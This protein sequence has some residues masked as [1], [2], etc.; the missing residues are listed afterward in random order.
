ML[1]EKSNQ[2]HEVQ[3]SDVK[4]KIDLFV[5]EV[6]ISD[7]LGNSREIE[8]V[9]K[10]DDKSWLM[11]GHFPGT[12]IIQCFCQGAMLLYYENNPDHDPEKNIFFLGDL[13]VKYRK[14][15]FFNET[16]KFKI[17]SRCYMGAVLLYEGECFLNGN[18]RCATISGSLSSKCRKTFL[19]LSGEESNVKYK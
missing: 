18:I 14:P 11:N 19:R 12:S 15:I 7:V 5:E 2:L 10:V 3:Q 17:I 9:V 8:Y 1:T 16:V 13:K 4:R 6:F